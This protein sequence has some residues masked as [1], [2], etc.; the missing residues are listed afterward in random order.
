ML[1]N[2]RS[3]MLTKFTFSL[4]QLGSNKLVIS[5]A[6][7]AELVDALDSDSVS[8]RMCEFKSRPRHHDDFAYCTINSNKIEKA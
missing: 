4:Y 5:H 2:F 7:V 8:D 6:G 1:F 3:G